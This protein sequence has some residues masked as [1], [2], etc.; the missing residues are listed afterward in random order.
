MSSHLH[1]FVLITVIVDEEIHHFTVMHLLLVYFHDLLNF[2]ISC[3]PFEKM[4]F[5][6]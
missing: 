2:F 1:V 4:V 5:I 3:N 6:E